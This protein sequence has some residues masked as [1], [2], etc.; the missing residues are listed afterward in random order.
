V[1]ASARNRAVAAQWHAY[2]GPCSN[3][4]EH[5]CNQQQRA[6]VVQ[7]GIST[8]GGC[9]LPSTSGPPPM[10]YTHRRPTLVH[11]LSPQLMRNHAGTKQL[12]LLL[13]APRKA[14]RAAVLLTRQAPTAVPA[15]QRS[16]PPPSC[17]MPACTKQCHDLW[18]AVRARQRNMPAGAV[19]HHPRPRKLSR[20]SQ[21]CFARNSPASLGM[22][23]LWSPG[24]GKERARP[25]VYA[26]ELP[27]L[28]VTASAKPIV[29]DL[30]CA[31]ACW[32]LRASS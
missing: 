12:I 13:P 1:A 2:H 17:A 10:T 9:R 19:Q 3:K 18:C 15:C 6:L 16:C 25:V 4:P 7:P 24:A 11:H 5:H 20:S 22:P 28:R 32:T 27:R 8:T 26:W 29:A 14:A 23:T 31:S 21:D 30:S